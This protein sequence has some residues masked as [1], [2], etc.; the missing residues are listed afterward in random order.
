M[1]EILEGL[2]GVL[3]LIDDTIIFAQNQEE[4]DQR[5]LADL[6]GL[7]E[8]NVTLNAEKCAFNKSK[9]LAF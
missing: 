5:L 9:I 1:N 8:A 3:C 4:H 6:Q 2:P 7:E